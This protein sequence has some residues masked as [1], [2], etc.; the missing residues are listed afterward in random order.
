MNEQSLYLLDT[1][2]LSSLV[3]QPQGRVAQHIAMVGEERV[4]TSIIVASELRFG[5]AKKQSSRV[6]QQV[7]AILDTIAILPLEVP[8]DVE[9]AHIRAYLERIGQLIGPN[10][11]LIAAHALSIKAFL[12]TANLNEFTRVPGLAVQNWLE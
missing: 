5:V 2:I 4:C 1:N 12:V 7:E 8:A 9:Y 6:A 11:L 10:D 3:R